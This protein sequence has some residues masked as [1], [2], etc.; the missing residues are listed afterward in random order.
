MSVLNI[1]VVHGHGA[2]LAV[3]AAA[4]TST[5]SAAAV[6]LQVP[7]TGAGAGSGCSTAR[8]S[9]GGRI[10]GAGRGIEGFDGILDD[11]AGELPMRSRLL[12]REFLGYPKL[13]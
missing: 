12:V 4:A 6:V 1:I 7:R 9:V 11:L 2:V 5:A 3:A 8:A 10:V 13:G